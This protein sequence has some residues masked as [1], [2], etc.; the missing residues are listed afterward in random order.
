[1]TTSRE[2]SSAGTSGMQRGRDMTPSRRGSRND[3]ENGGG[4]PASS[5]ARSPSRSRERT[6]F[7][8]YRDS[9]LTRVL[10]SSLGGNAVTLLLVTVHPSLQ[11]L[12]QSMTSL[13]FASKARCVEN[14]VG[15]NPDVSTKGT[16]EKST[17]DA[18]KKIIEG[19]QNNLR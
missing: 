5:I 9:K 3:D 6:E 13:R 7:I 1:M 11:F 16:D 15:V 14:H 12:E 18:Q 17:I 4:T 8:P 2:A 19:L 10:R